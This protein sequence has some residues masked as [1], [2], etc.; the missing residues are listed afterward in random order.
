MVEGKM[1]PSISESSLLLLQT[2]SAIAFPFALSLR[3][4]VS[5]SCGVKEKG[6]CSAIF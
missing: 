2:G 3:L 6:T 1:E 4:G 5:P